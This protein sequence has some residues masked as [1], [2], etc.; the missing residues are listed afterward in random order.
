MN[1]ISL[2]WLESIT[3][4]G[5]RFRSIR[6]KVFCEKGVLKNFGNFKGKHLCSRATLLKKRLQHRCFPVKFAKF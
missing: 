5:L 6:P 3:D 2:K 4:K 1:D